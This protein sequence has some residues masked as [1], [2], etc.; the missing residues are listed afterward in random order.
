ML[1]L[2][3]SAPRSDRQNAMQGSGICAEQTTGRRVF[4]LCTPSKVCWGGS[5]GGSGGGEGA[6]C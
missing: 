1:V 2:S 4:P 5:E 6:C 3:E